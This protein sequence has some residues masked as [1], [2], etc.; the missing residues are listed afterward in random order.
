[1]NIAYRKAI[2]EGQKKQYARK[3]Q[4]IVTYGAA[5]AK[6]ARSKTAHARIRNIALKALNGKGA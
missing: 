2:S 1:M 5:L 6:I 4:I 3:R